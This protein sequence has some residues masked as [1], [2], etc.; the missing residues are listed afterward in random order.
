MYYFKTRHLLFMGAFLMLTAWLFA[1]SFLEEAE[2]YKVKMT[3]CI[4]DW[5]KPP[6]QRFDDC[7][8]A[9][10]IQYDV[11]ADVLKARAAMA[12]E[13]NPEATK[14]YDTGLMM[15][16]EELANMC[17][18][19][20][21]SPKENL[22]CFAKHLRRLLNLYDN[23]YPAALAHYHDGSEAGQSLHEYPNCPGATNCYARKTMAYASCLKDYPDKKLLEIEACA[24]VRSSVGSGT[25]WFG[26]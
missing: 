7:I 2:K 24:E 15:L 14:E 5:K 26:H 12:S 19:N 21:K 22:F 8:E 17:H 20:P 18:I 9:A 1:D 16:S 11:R 10:H 23:D 6:E 4:I 13:F 3:P 25:L